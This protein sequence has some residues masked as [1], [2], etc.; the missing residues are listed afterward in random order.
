M[1]QTL[2]L[3]LKGAKFGPALWSSGTIVLSIATY[4]Q[5]YG[6]PFAAGFVALIFVHEMGHYVAAVQRGLPVGLPMFIPFV[7]AFIQLK[8]EP[9][10]AETEAYVAIAGP[11]AGTLAAFGCYYIWRSGEGQIWLALAKSGLILNLFNLIPISPLD[12]GRITAVLSPRIWF[13]GVPMLLGVWWYLPSPMLILIAV[14]ALPQLMKAW[15]YDSKAPENVAYYGVPFA[16][17][18]EYMTLYLGLAVILGLM[19]NELHGLAR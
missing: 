13:V 19:I 17:R 8:D 15:N 14:F 1:L 4:A 18:L 11:I 2:F 3:L 10:D 9:K 12:G 7:G 5:L 16:V 6:W